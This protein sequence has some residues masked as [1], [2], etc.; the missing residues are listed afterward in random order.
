MVWYN[1]TGRVTFTFRA[2]LISLRKSTLV[3]IGVQFSSV[4]TYMK[5]VT[6]YVMIM[7]FSQ[8]CEN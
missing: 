7:S 5:F 1:M 8:I 3:Q 4:S 6:N 2:Q